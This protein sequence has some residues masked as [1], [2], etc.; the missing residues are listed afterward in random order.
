MTPQA[1]DATAMRLIEQAAS[2]GE[3]CPKNETIAVAIGYSSVSAS[4]RVLNRLEANGLIHV[5]RGAINRVVTILAT[6][7]RT[8]GVVHHQ[9]W[10]FQTD[11]VPPPPSAPKPYKPRQ[12]A[13]LSHPA[14]NREPCSRCGVR[15][16]YGCQHSTSGSTSS[17]ST[18]APD[19]SPP[20]HTISTVFIPV[21]Q[22][23]ALVS[24]PLVGA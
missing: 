12:P 2:L 16:D 10:R 20:N 5:E 8:A 18:S 13:L 24:P 22:G 4:C 7:K 1:A 11:R 14:I 15:A 9:H 3:P 17:T 19:V 23:H 21:P 6:G